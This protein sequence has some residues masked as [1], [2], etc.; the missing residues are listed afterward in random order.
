[1][2]ADE[3]ATRSD[4]RAMMNLVM[5]DLVG[6]CYERCSVNLWDERDENSKL[7]ERVNRALDVKLIGRAH[8]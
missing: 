1:M 8:V 3:H 6:G 2:K 5:V 4:T 7:L